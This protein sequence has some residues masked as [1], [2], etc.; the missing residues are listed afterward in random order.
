MTNQTQ[1]EGEA[2]AA[3]MAANLTQADFESVIED[4]LNEKRSDLDY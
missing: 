1:G 4:N 2:T 3:A